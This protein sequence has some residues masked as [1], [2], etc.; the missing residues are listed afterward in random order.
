MG[1]AQQ[2]FFEFGH[3][4]NLKN[5]NGSR[6]VGSILGSIQKSFPAEIDFFNILGVYFNPIA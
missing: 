1:A 5:H 6:A 3:P 2:H 4:G